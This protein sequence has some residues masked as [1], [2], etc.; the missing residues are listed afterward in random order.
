MTGQA[1]VSAYSASKGALISLTKS[2][3]L[4]LAGENIRVNCV[5]PGVVNTEMS[6]KL[7]SFMTEQ[8]IEGIKKMHPLGFGTPRDVANAISFLLADTSRWITGSV[9]VVDG[10][11]TAH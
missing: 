1:G 9:L 4:E 11:Y 5:A 2:L 8:Q 6:D 3:A 7:F 10:G